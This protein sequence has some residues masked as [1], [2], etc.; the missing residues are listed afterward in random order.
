MPAGDG[1]S[2]MQFMQMLADVVSQRIAN[3]P[4]K[5]FEVPRTAPDGTKTTQPVM[6]PQII[7]E[8]TDEMK[9]NNDLVKKLIKALNKNYRVGV[10]ALRAQ[11]SKRG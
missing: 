2:P 5:V 11:R 7:A 9:A 1:M 10:R 4:P 3:Q 6:L 8:L